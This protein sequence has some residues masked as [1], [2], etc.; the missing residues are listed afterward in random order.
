MNKEKEKLKQIIELICELLDATALRVGD[1][2]EYI[3]F[4]ISESLFLSSQIENK[5]SSLIFVE[6]S[7]SIN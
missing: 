1:S 3:N 2:T 7:E 4:Y 5:V 6:K